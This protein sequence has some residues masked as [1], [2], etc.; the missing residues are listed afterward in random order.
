M[1][2]KPC[3]LCGNPEI[4]LEK[5]QLTRNYTIHCNACNFAS[6]KIPEYEAFDILNG[7]KKLKDNLF[8]KLW[9][10]RKT[11]KKHKKLPLEGKLKDSFLFEC[12]I[13]A[14]IDLHTQIYSDDSTSLSEQKHIIDEISCK[15]CQCHL[16]TYSFP[17]SLLHCLTHIWN[18][19]K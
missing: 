15:K 14:G 16:T 13:C 3:P 18:T 9:N 19:R 12:P 5:N 7:P 10:K 11:L 6:A 17:L 2:F 4:K 1:Q 8:D